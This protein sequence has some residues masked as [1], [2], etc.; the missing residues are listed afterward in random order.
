MLARARG[1]RPPVAAVLGTLLLAA[2]L[3]DFNTHLSSL[4][5]VA[6]ALMHGPFGEVK[7]RMCA[8]IGLWGRV[9]VW[10]GGEAG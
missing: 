6:R 1:M 4:T 9:Q 10:K 8:L 7:V 5:P 3:L 2:H